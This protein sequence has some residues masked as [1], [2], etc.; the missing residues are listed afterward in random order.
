M[1][2]VGSGMQEPV[3][4]TIQSHDGLAL[5][6]WDHGGDGPPLLLSHCTGTLG[7]IW[8]PIVALLGGEYRVIAPDTRGQGDSER[9]PDDDGFAWSLSG[10]DLLTAIDALGIAEGLQAVGHS[11][12][13][14]HV[15][16]AELQRPG[17][18]GRVILIDPIVVPRGLFSGERPLAKL[19]KKRINDFDSLEDARARFVAKP[20][21]ATWTP[22]TV[23]AY[24]AHAFRPRDDGGYTLKCPGY[25]EA[26]YYNHGGAVEVYEAFDSLGFDPLLITGEESNVRA[27]AENL[28]GLR[29]GARLEILENTSHFV[30]QERPEE[31]AQLIRE[32]LV[33]D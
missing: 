18:F 14:A 2:L 3:L 6:V 13:G 33:T 21:M 19:V 4:H 32:W 25:V 5:N 28:H 30:P 10:Q 1:P 9:P 11:A 29:A 24:I 22:E 27:L 8:D 31:V 12:G 20:P 17:T 15:G 16:Y 23:D 7:R 26:I